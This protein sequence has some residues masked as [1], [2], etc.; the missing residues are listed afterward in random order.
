MSPDHYA[1][2]ATEEAAIR[3][4]VGE[5]CQGGSPYC[6][7]GC[8][9]MVAIR[10]RAMA[11]PARGGAM[12]GPDAGMRVT[13]AKGE[14]WTVARCLPPCDDEP[15]GDENPWLVRIADEPHSCVSW[16]PSCIREIRT[17]DG[18]VLWRAQ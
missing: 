18:R 4:E 9:V 2:A 7:G 5:C 12:P 8:L 17:P 3:A 15:E 14:R 13:D 10:K 6:A 1:T 11:G 16:H